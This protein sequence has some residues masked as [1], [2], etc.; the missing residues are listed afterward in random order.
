MTDTMRTGSTRALKP[1]A[2]GNGRRNRAFIAI[3]ATCA[4]AGIAA[5]GIFQP[6][7]TSS[8]ADASVATPSLEEITQA[9]AQNYQAS[10]LAGTEENA[11]EGA[12]FDRGESVQAELEPEP[13]PEP[14]PA[15]EPSETTE[16]TEDSGNSGS[17]NNSGSSSNDSEESSSSNSSSNSGGSDYPTGGSYSGESP[18]AIAQQMLNDRGMGGQWGCFEAIIGQE[19]GWDPYATN[20]SSGA[21][22]IPQALPGSRMSTHGSDW[23]TN[24]ATQI[25]WAID[26]MN[27]R[28][29]SPCGAYDF[30]FTQGN[31]WY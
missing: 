30:K 22:G 25:A 29:G 3:G 1:A 21:Y 7:A 8:V 15:P 17:A 20:P 5:V 24:P 18:Q 19:S 16:P 14:E 31:G 13:E 23:R 26:Y 4:I 11:G 10:L 27:D 2:L 28:Y 6:G 12:G 9:Q